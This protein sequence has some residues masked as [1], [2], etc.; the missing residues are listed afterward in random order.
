MI[1]VDVLMEEIHKVIVSVGDGEHG[2]YERECGELRRSVA[3]ECLLILLPR[4]LVGV[5]IEF[6]RLRLDVQEFLMDR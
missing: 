3:V 2:V 1:H 6:G 4:L 5:D